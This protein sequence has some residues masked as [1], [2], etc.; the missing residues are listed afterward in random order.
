MLY[1]SCGLVTILLSENTPHSHGSVATSSFLCTGKLIRYNYWHNLAQFLSLLCS[2]VLTTV[3]A[4]SLG[5]P[6]CT[7]METLARLTLFP[8]LHCSLRYRYAMQ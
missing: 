1:F 6:T 2:V 3:V 4:A 5:L 8:F 7:A